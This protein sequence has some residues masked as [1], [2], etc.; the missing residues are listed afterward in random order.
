MDH[1]NLDLEKVSNA[2]IST[3]LDVASSEKMKKQPSERLL[4]AESCEQLQL[5]DDAFVAVTEFPYFDGCVDDAI[6]DLRIKYG[7]DLKNRL[8]IEVKPL[9]NKS[10]YWNYSKFFNSTKMKKDFH[11][12]PSIILNDIDKMDK[13]PDP[14]ENNEAFGFLLILAGNSEIN[15]SSD[16]GK[17]APPQPTQKKRLSIE[18]VA[19][20]CNSR[21]NNIKD[22]YLPVNTFFQIGKQTEFTAILWIAEWE[23]GKYPPA[24]E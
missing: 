16:L 18:Q 13:V 15:Q 5:Q 23:K 7:A 11:S 12:L 6:A 9:F 19:S 1:V 4:V 24:S 14:K 10:N 22:M 21:F 2:I 8:W 3:F 17:L 20:L